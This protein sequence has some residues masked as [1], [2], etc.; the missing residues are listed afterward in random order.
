MIEDIYDLYLLPVTSPVLC[1]Q[2]PGK[3]TE[4]KRCSYGVD[5]FDDDSRPDAVVASERRLLVESDAVDGERDV[6]DVGGV[7]AVA[8]RLLRQ[9]DPHLAGGLRKSKQALSG[10]I[11]RAT[12]EI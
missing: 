11:S 3:V 6:R 12:I 1:P 10:L 5:G 9:R 2:V 7:N 8:A 4:K